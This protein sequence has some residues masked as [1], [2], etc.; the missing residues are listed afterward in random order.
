MTIPNASG[1]HDATI[2]AFPQQ[3]VSPVIQDSDSHAVVVPLPTELV[4]SHELDQDDEFSL[5]TE[6]QA[7]RDQGAQPPSERARKRA[8]NVAVHALAG[9]GQSRAEI[10]QRLA[11]RDL[12]ESAVS[13][14]VAR[15]EERGLIDDEALAADL[16][17]RY[18][19]RGGMGR[20]ALS[21]KLRQRHIAPEVIARALETVTDDDE[22]ARLREVAEDRA[23][24][25][26]SL[27]PAVAK[28]R[29]I[30]YLQRRGFNGSD[31]Y[32]VVNEVL[33]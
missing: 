23:R 19:D 26:R 11:A 21:H 28:R 22:S 15:L 6:N 27:A 8:Q 29:L 31:I 2:I 7:P 16:V 5:G 1:E 25:L 4:A 24:A 14:E 32:S 30:A 18:G 10:E 9:R 17:E 13:D 3:R 33:G 12:P 20:Q